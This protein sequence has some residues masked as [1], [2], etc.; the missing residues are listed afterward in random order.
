MTLV[1][2]ATG[3]V[4][5]T[6]VHQL[7][8]AGESVR[9]LRRERSALDLLGDAAGSVEHV[10]GDVTDPDAVWDATEGVRRVAH[11]AAVVAFGRRARRRL[12]D[13]NVGGTDH[14]VNAAL[15]L[16]VERLVHVSSIAALGRPA[17]PGG[18]IDESTAWATSAANSGYARSKREAERSVQRAVAEG[19][20]AVIVNPAVVFGPGR[21]GENTMVLA[22]RLAAGRVPF[23]PTGSTA[24]VDVADV[25]TGIRAAFAHGGSGE[26]YV[27]A[28][29]TLPLAEIFG[30]LA[31]ALGVAPP[32]RLAPPALLVAAGAL[33]EAWGAVTR[34]DPALTR[35]TA[36]SASA[37]YRYSA[38]KARS[39][40]G[41]AFRPFRETAAR[42]AAAL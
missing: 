4:G 22:E 12:W 29:E 27:L 17:T 33:A 36:R 15:D 39:D 7:L 16:G 41:L 2:G 1:T 9:I 10:V 3:F 20:D 35:A 5:S 24:V 6:L 13:V 26:R 37:S 34:T 32:Q 8:A 30:T 21:R 38:D 11:V 40:L 19:L 14:V 25:A 18:P 31:D 23:V 42:V 28:A